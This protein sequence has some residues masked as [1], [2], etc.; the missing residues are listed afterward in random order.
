M[1]LERRFLYVYSSFFS[2]CEI[3]LAKTNTQSLDFPPW[4]EAYH[5]EPTCLWDEIALKTLQKMKGES[6]IPER[7]TTCLHLF[8]NVKTVIID[9]KTVHPV[10][11]VKGITLELKII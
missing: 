9:S 10:N 5:Q 1:I 8:V 3:F 11:H 4:W 7:K 6:V 2:Q